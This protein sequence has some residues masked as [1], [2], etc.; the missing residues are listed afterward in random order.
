[1]KFRVAHVEVPRAGRTVHHAVISGLL[2]SVLCLALIAAGVGT[3]HAA[4]ALKIVVY[5]G[6][7]NIGQR[8]VHEALDRGHTVTVVV[9]DP[10]ALAEQPPRLR[11]LKG[12]VLDSAEVT[13][14]ISGADVVVSAVSFRSQTHNL[15]GFSRAA[16]SL[17]TALRRLGAGAPYSRVP[18]LIV[19]GGAGSLK[20]PPGVHIEI[21]PAWR[22]EVTGQ[23]NSLAY[24]R[25]ISDVRWTY[26]SPA[27]MITPGTRTG[28]FRLGGDQMI[29]D[30][31]GNSRISMEDYAVAVIDEAEKP[32]HVR[33]RFTIGY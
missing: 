6:T 9:R 19:V 17:V 24:Y 7:G 20:Q 11:V 30:A 2:A 1:M 28:Q 18:Y 25:T 22:E 16:A 4:T 3:V 13:R 29:T 14:T 5:G 12:N 23:N 27:F 26:F 31:A 15:D 8:I 33:K 21:P 10:S 32:M